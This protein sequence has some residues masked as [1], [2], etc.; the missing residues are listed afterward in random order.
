M[1]A[2]QN[3]RPVVKYFKKR[4]ENVTAQAGLGTC[5]ADRMI[6]WAGVL[7]VLA[8]SFKEVSGYIRRI[9]F[10]ISQRM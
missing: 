7:A 9:I 4:E 2:P 5:C 6:T 3:G 10:R 1:S 8:G